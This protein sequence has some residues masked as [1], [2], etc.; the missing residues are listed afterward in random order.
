MVNTPQIVL[1]DDEP[2]FA[3]RRLRLSQGEKI[4]AA[5]RAASAALL[6]GC[7]ALS[8]PSRRPGGSPERAPCL[9]K[10]TWP[11]PK[12][13]I[14]PAPPAHPLPFELAR[15]RGSLGMRPR[16]GLDHLGDWPVL[17]AST[18]SRPSC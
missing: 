3:L 11:L 15:M 8:C 5:S 2:A 7:T 1:S 9:Q 12:N 10:T 14:P 17:R 13:R 16:P 18:S 6:G 4:I